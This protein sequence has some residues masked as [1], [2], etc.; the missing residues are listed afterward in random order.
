M[1]DW[2]KTL[3]I[4]PS[5]FNDDGLA[6]FDKITNHDLVNAVIDGALIMFLTGQTFKILKIMNLFNNLMCFGE[7]SKEG[8]IY[9]QGI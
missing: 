5:Y 9:I 3:N 4:K 2:I 7:V 6:K 1:S 8:K